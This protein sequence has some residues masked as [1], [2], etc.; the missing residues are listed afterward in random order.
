M[1]GGTVRYTSEKAK[2]SNA[3]TQTS[4]SVLSLHELAEL[5][6]YLQ[7]AGGL[8]WQSGLGNLVTVFDL[9]PFGPTTSPSLNISV[10]LQFGPPST[11]RA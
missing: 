6:G 1:V 2:Y 11:L 4:A 3:S 5:V 9:E 10:L 8:L 7:V